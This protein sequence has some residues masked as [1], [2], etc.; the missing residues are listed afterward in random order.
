MTDV[1]SKLWIRNYVIMLINEVKNVPKKTRESQE[2]MKRIVKKHRTFAGKFQHLLRLVVNDGADF[3]MNQLDYFLNRMQNIH[4][5]K[6]D[7]EKVDKEL[8]QTYYDKY[9]SPVIN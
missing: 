3:D 1:K 8:G 7:V 6:E 4:E 5:G 9:V 2:F